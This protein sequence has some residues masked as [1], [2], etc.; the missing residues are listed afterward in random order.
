MEGLL[1]GVR[2][3]SYAREA[4]RREKVDGGSVRGWGKSERGRGST[5]EGGSLT[6]RSLMDVV[7]GEG[8]SHALH[9]CIALRPYPQIHLVVVVEDHRLH[10][11]RMC[12]CARVQYNRHTPTPYGAADADADR[13]TH[14]TL[15]FYTYTHTHTHVCMYACMYVCICMY[16]YVYVDVH[17]N[18]HM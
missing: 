8:K 13:N 1:R 3:H 7:L 12:V 5:K 11:S 18:T 9:Y 10:M 15:T 6:V 16:V 14:R 2:S 4:G 17:T